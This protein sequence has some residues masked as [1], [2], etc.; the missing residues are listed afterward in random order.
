MPK[1]PETRAE[2]YAEAEELLRRYHAG[3]GDPHKVLQEAQVHATLASI[4]PADLRA[5][6]LPDGLPR[7]TT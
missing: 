2:H 5:D 6:P 7:P 4:D 3:S 1:H